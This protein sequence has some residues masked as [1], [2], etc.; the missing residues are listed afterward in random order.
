MGILGFNGVAICSS[1]IDGP[2][3]VEVSLFDSEYDFLAEGTHLT[4][5][6]SHT[7][8]DAPGAML[9]PPHA[10]YGHDD[11]IPPN[12][13]FDFLLIEVQVNVSAEGVYWIDVWLGHSITF[14]LEVPYLLP[15]SQVVGINLRGSD[16]YI[17]GID[18]P[19]LVEITLADNEFNLLDRNENFTSDYSYTDF[20]PPGAI[21]DPPHSDYG[22]DMDLPPN[23]LYDHLVIN[24]SIYVYEEGLYDIWIDLFGA[25]EIT[26]GNTTEFLTVGS[27]HVEVLLNGSH[28]FASESNGPYHAN[29]V[30]FNS[31]GW[32]LDY[33][34]Y[35]T[36]F[37]SYTD[38]DPRASS[39]P[40]P[41]T[42]LSAHLEEYALEDV[43]VSWSYQRN[44]GNESLVHHYDIF[45]GNVLDWNGNGYELLDSVLD[46]GEQT[47]NYLHENAGEG[48]P[49]NYFYYV[50]G[51]SLINGSSCT[52][53]QVGKFTRPLNQGPNLISVP[54][55]QSNESFE[56]V[57]QTVEYDKAWYYDSPSEEWK[58]YMK[59]KGYRRDLWSI[60]HIMGVWVNVTASSNLTIAG[61]V[62]DQTTIHLYRGWNLVSFPSF[63]KSYTIADM[64]A[65]IG[66][67]RVEGYDFTALPNF[68]E[69]L[70]DAE[71]LQAGYAYWVKVDT[72][73]DW[74]VEMA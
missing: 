27:R 30:L 17:S 14:Q 5:P 18:G 26:M 65:E 20:D 37:Y 56:M 34:A 12:G 10:D 16:I 39:P 24:A 72:N 64:R 22:L 48:D 51:V 60:N 19:Y 11:D 61:I 32:F 33:D 67:T 8:F 43:N 73:V 59:S 71:V 36:S 7:E 15:G 53:S 58:W 29:L 49:S 44:E 6:Y 35:T 70:G 4:A 45:Y 63:N 28:I 69:V 21:F 55:V 68:L 3:L 42:N 62:P 74:I 9:N 66:A 50:C 23:G 41:P 13:L 31:T 25:D 1:G 52:S 38:F 54:L 47:Y 40:P 2:Y 57:L 46:S